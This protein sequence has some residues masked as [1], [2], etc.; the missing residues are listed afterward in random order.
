MTTTTTT[1]TVAAVRPR[2][3]WP[4]E[5]GAQAAFRLPGLRRRHAPVHGATVRL[6]AGTCHQIHAKAF[7][8]TLSYHHVRAMLRLSTARCSMFTQQ[9][10]C[11]RVCMCVSVL[12]SIVGFSSPKYLEAEGG[13]C[14]SVDDPSQHLQRSFSLQLKHCPPTTIFTPLS[15]F[16]FLFFCRGA[17]EDHLVGAPARVQ[18]RD[19]GRPP[20]ARLRSDGGR[21]QGQV[22]R[23]LHKED[24]ISTTTTTTTTTTR[25]R[26]LSRALTGMSTNMA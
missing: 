24:R 18:D 6:R 26:S 5:G 19:V 3:I 20:G 12:R 15:S 16:F 22:Q 2:P 10:Q 25:P 7:I 14:S 17:G 4:G 1:T 9:L 11:C 21:T 23:A 13:H 8:S